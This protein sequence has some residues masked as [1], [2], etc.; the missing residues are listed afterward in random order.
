MFVSFSAF[1][2]VKLELVHDGINTQHWED[3]PSISPDGRFL[4]FTRSEAEDWPETDFRKIYRIDLVREDSSAELLG[5]ADSVYNV[6]Y[7]NGNSIFYTNRRNQQAKGYQEFFKAE[8]S[9]GKYEVRNMT[10]E[11]VASYAHQVADGSIY[12]FR[13]DGAEGAGLYRSQW[14]GK[15]FEAPIWLGEQL[16]ELET[17]TFDAFV[18]PDESWMIFTSYFEQDG[19]SGRTGFYFA[20]NVRGKW[21]KSKIEGLPY[22]WGANVTPDFEFFIF[23]DGSDIYKCKLKDLNIDYF[24][25]P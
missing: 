8:Y 21:L 6:S 1:G 16:S 17:T 2:Q 12:F 18:A 20:E 11:I 23:T 9:T 3:S 14:N 22:G 15:H 19:E 5:F 4:I 24:K 13:Y 7:G 10:S 25:K